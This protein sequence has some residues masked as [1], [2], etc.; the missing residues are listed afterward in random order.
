MN[1]LCA[2][3]LGLVLLVTSCQHVVAQDADTGK[4]IDA[5]EKQYSELIAKIK[6]L[7]QELV[8]LK[9]ENADLKQQAGVP[10]KNANKIRSLRDVLAPGSKIS[11]DWSSIAPAKG[12]TGDWFLEVT[13]R[14]K[15]DFTGKFTVTIDK[16]PAGGV[17]FDV[18]GTISSDDHVSFKTVGAKVAVTVIGKRVKDKLNLDYQSA[19]GTKS[20][21]T[22]LQ[23][24]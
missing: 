11:G 12:T 5:L 24:R 2:L 18:S 9:K 17:V 6:V 15:D 8:D 13:T 19:G 23:V 4:R 3:T 16:D 22:A 10:A 21:M 7:E 20:T 14:E 1:R